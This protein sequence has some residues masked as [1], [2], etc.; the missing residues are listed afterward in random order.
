MDATQLQTEAGKQQLA[1]V[2]RLAL[3]AGVITDGELDIQSQLLKRDC[4]TLEAFS[5]EL[6]RFHRYLLWR[7]RTWRACLELED[8]AEEM[9]AARVAANGT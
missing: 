2:I 7:L 4:P 5:A 8:A 6:G 1:A 3:D 9:D